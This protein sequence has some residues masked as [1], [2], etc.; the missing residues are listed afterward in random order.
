MQDSAYISSYFTYFNAVSKCSTWLEIKQSFLSTV[1]QAS[2]Y[3][4]ALNYRGYDELGMELG[5]KMIL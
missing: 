3:S 5:F 2:I 1:E 4:S